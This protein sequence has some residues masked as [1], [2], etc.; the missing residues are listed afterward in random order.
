MNKSSAL[1]LVGALLLAAMARA[2]VWSAVG[3][4]RG[5]AENPS[6]TEPLGPDDGELFAVTRDPSGPID[7]C[8][9]KVVCRPAPPGT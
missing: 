1:P 4:A 8:T 5:T 7:W 2:D 3:V 9:L 6:C